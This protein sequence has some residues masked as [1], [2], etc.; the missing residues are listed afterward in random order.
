MPSGGTNFQKRTSQT[1]PSLLG[2][3]SALPYIA[4]YI[5]LYTP[6]YSLYTPIYPSLLSPGGVIYTLYIPIYTPLYPYIPLYR[7]EGFPRTGYFIPG[8]VGIGAWLPELFLFGFRAPLPGVAPPPQT[9]HFQSASGLPTWV[10]FTP[11]EFARVG[12]PLA[13]RVAA[14]VGNAGSSDG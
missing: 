9:P 1:K 5:A 11:R 4:L 6:I 7:S 2:F 14:R 10:E 8:R 12:I 3:W 13:L